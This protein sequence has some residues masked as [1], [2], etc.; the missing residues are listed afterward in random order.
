LKEEEK[1]KLGQVRCGVAA[2]R[3]LRCGAQF[4]SPKCF[5]G[6]ESGE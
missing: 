6:A 2:Q 4:T 3:F 5:L 1:D